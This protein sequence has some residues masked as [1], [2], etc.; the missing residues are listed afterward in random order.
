MKIT[1]WIRAARDGRGVAMRS[2]FKMEDLDTPAVQ[3]RGLRIF[4]ALQGAGGEENDKGEHI[5]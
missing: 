1:T 4:R 5:K 3:R 2:D